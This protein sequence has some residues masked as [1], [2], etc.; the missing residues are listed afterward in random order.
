MVPPSQSPVHSQFHPG[1][2]RRLPDALHALLPQFSALADW[3]QYGTPKLNQRLQLL[4]PTPLLLLRK[5][6]ALPP[7]IMRVWTKLH[8]ILHIRLYLSNMMSNP[9]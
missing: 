3:F 8:D 7:K 2:P 4:L 6:A 9:Y 5:I 1:D